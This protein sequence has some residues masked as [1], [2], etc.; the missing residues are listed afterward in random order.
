MFIEKRYKIQ[1]L[2]ENNDNNSFQIDQI[3]KT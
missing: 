1:R 2:N 3:K